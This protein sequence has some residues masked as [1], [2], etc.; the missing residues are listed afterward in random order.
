MKGIV[1]KLVAGAADAGFVYATDVV[2][3]GG[4]IVAINL[5]PELEPE[6]AYG[7]VVVAASENAE[8]ADSSSPGFS[9]ARARRPLPMP[10]SCL[11]EASAERPDVPARPGGTADLSVGFL[12]IP[13]AAI[14]LEAGPAELWTRSATRPRW[15]RCA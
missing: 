13:V 11:P 5:P 7:V 14:F 10:A 1:G 12:T 4:D 6:V 2:A 3:A 8:L 9:R 15:T